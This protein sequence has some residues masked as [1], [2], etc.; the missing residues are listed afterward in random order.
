MEKRKGRLI[1]LSGPSGAGKGTVIRELARRR[2]LEL[3]VSCTTRAPRPGE[4]DGREYYFLTPAEFAA[5]AASD[6]FLEHAEVFGNSYG[7][8]RDIVLSRLEDGQ[9][10]LLEIDVQGAEQVKKN[11]P[12]AVRIFLMPPSEEE[13]LRR[14]KGRGTETEEQVHTRFAAARQ[15]MAQAAHYDHVIINDQVNRAADEIEA[16]LDGRKGEGNA[17]S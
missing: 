4:K 8:P 12:P 13:L 11:Y 3:S 15:E 9:D 16:I 2:P 5:R 7:T 6:G 10:V 1:V 14:L 17:A